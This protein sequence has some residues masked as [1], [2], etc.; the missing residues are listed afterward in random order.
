M[1]YKSLVLCIVL[2]VS[3][4][5]ASIADEAPQEG[6]QENFTLSGNIYDQGGNPAGMTSMKLDSRE[7]VWASDGTYSLNNIS[8]GDHTVRAYFLNN[9]HT[10]VYRQIYIDSN[11]ILDW[12]VGKNWATSKVYDSAGELIENPTLTTVKLVE[13][14]ES[15][16][17]E[18]GRTSIG[19]HSIGEYYTM[20]AYY[21]DIDHST[22]YIHFKLQSGSMDNK[23][24]NDFEFHHGKNSLYGYLKDSSGAAMEEVTVS[25]GEQ[26][27]TTNNDGFY[28]LQNLEVGSEKTLTFVH[29]NSEVAPSLTHTVTIGES[30]LNHTATSEVNMPGNAS[31]ITQVQVIPINEPFMIEWQGGA[32]TEGYSLHMNEVQVLDNWPAPEYQFVPTE[33]GNYEFSLTAE[34]VNGSTPTFQ[35]LV[36][37]VLPEQSD[38]DLWAVGMEWNYEIDYYP[39]ATTRE[40]SMT[41]VGKEPIEDAFGL[42]QDTFLVRMNGPHYDPGEKSYRW[43]DSE[44]LLYVHTYW[45]ADPDISSYFTEGTLGWN[46]TDSQGGEADLL[47]ANED[48][49]MHFNRTNVIGVPGH[50]NGYDDTN[51]IVTITRD[52]ELTTAAGT[53]MTTY[54][55]ITDVNDGVKSWELWYNDTVRNWVKKIDRLPGSHSDYFVSELTS[56]DVPITPQFMTEESNFDTKDFLLEWA[57]FQGATSYELYENGELIYTGDS[58]SIMFEDK[59]DGNYEYQLEAVMSENY[60]ISSQTKSIDVFYVVKP[61][62]VDV[63]KS[64]EGSMEATTNL[65]VDSGD[66]VVLS[67]S[68]IESPAYYS[69]VVQ[70]GN[71]SKEIYNGT[72]NTFTSDDFD[73]GL[74]RIRVISMDTDGK[75]SEPSDSVFVRVND[76]DSANEAEDVFSNIPTVAVAGVALLAILLLI[77]ILRR[78]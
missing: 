77:P 33:T 70:N 66:S 36:L 58:T 17:P 35:K 72:G 57:P 9:G 27:V 23:F 14:D 32:Y 25:D 68:Q 20:R 26:S 4:L 67:W 59:Q 69:V 29:G 50:P 42:M 28:L 45:V 56:F 24:A 18:N 31:F 19:P 13:T 65:E 75:I 48:L 37:I 61:V 5:P 3:M 30:W 39:S 52:V 64:D 15:V 78:E 10:V 47:S 11:T 60:K 16:I 76:V 55:C 12:H 46:F 6:P 62:V 41:V 73:I 51:N 38:T 63:T 74:N 53:F 44:N 49:N 2:A 7:S 34:N 43:V 54:I 40:V 21:G 1:K 8:E 71:S 22:Q